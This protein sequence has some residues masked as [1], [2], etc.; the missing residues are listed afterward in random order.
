MILDA[1]MDDLAFVF[2]KVLLPGR[3]PFLYFKSTR[4]ICTY[5]QSI[6]AYF[7]FASRENYLARETTCQNL[8]LC[9]PH[10]DRNR[11]FH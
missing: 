1:E 10:C 9:Y 7:C 11:Y 2:W 5:H 4:V 6:H 8:L 3:L